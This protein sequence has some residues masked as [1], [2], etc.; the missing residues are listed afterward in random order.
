VVLAASVKKELQTSA[1]FLERATSHGVWIVYTPG[2][3]DAIA[4]ATGSDAEADAADLSPDAAADE[5]A[6]AATGPAKSNW[7]ALVREAAGAEEP[8]GSGEPA[9]VRRG[10]RV[11]HFSLGLCDVLMS[12]GEQLKVRDAK[13]PGRI[14]AL[15]LSL[16]DIEPPVLSG[17]KRVFRLTRKAE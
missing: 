4:L 13:G 6:P 14:R 8:T 1:G 2:S 5:A 3:E 16:L 9:I 15:R 10:D 7:A 11:Q 12:D 17:G